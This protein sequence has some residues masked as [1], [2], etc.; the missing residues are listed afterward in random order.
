MLL[1]IGQLTRRYPSK[2][3]LADVLFL[4]ASIYGI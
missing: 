4:D 3:D 1:I 2:Y